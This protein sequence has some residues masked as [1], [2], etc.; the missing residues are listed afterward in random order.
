MYATLPRGR[1][2]SMRLPRLGLPLAAVAV[3]VLLVGVPSAFG[4]SVP[5]FED[6]PEGHVAEAAIRW[7]AES[8]VTVGVGGNRFGIG[9]TLTGTRW[10]LFCAERSI[11]A[12]VR[13]A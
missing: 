13:A 2:G 8:G 10:S 6:V 9:E 1:M 3:F 12:T 7:A 11:R 5:D 4:H